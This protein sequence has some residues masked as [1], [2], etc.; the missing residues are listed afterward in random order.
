MGRNDLEEFQRYDDRAMTEYFAGVDQ[1]NERLM[2]V[3][4]DGWK[5]VADAIRAGLGDIAEAIRRRDR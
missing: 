5:S 3:H 4:R 2:R 1:R